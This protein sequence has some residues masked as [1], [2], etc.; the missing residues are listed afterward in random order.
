MIATFN[1]LNNFNAQRQLIIHIIRLIH[2]L[3][4]VLLDIISWLYSPYSPYHTSILFSYQWILELICSHSEQI[5]SELG[6]KI[7]TFLQ[8]VSYPWHSSPSPALQAHLRLW[9]SDLWC[10]LTQS[11]SP[12]LRTLSPFLHLS[13][14]LCLQ[15]S[16]FYFSISSALRYLCAVCTTLAFIP[17]VC[18][19]GYYIFCL[20]SYSPPLLI[21]FHLH[22]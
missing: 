19:S 13:C 9:L 10:Y 18:S 6:L 15:Y 20:P 16:L 12:D 2:V 1:N 4:T 11:V 7:Y 21:W 17:P 5:R 3:L 22:I 8:L 14:I